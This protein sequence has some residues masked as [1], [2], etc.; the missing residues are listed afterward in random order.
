[1]TEMIRSGI[2]TTQDS[3]YI[4]FHIDSIDG[5]AE[6]ARDS[7]FRLVLGRGSWDLHGLAPEE[8]TEDIKTSINES[9]KVA[10]KWHNGDM[11][12]VIY[13]SSLLSQVSDELIIETK[14]A[15]REDGLGWGMHI[16][17]P[18]ASH[19]NDPRTK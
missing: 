7:G 13:E 1:M 19:K 8:L 15:A 4:N 18:L 14:R 2:T 17:G 5:I 10:S 11:I 6:S 12:K 3:H 16:Q 9:R